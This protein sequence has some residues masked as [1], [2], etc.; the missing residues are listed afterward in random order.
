[1]PVVAFNYPDL[2]G[3]IGT[4]YVDSVYT[5]EIGD[6]RTRTEWLVKVLE[7]KGN[8]IDVGGTPGNPLSASVFKGVKET[9]EEQPDMKL[10]IDRPIDTNFS[11]A[12]EQKAVAGVLA[13]Y[14]DV[15]GVQNECG[16]CA[17]G[18]IR[19]FQ[20]AKRPLVPWTSDDNNEL[21]CLYKELKPSNPEFEL[22]TTAARNTT[23]RPALH[24]V[25]AAVNKV[26]LDEPSVF[27]MP[28]VE[29]ST[30]PER[31]PVCVGDAPPGAIFSSAL[32][33]EQAIAATK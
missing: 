8:I 10:L 32:T 27:N 21:A 9:L 28:V 4:D 30:D 16:T 31:Q 25:L 7:G 22:F 14:K 5:D 18:G 19:A 12:D 33:R 11:A 29:D 17:P 2:G 3:K 1:M 26:G 23:I 6:A 24:K 20:A 15:D 13:K